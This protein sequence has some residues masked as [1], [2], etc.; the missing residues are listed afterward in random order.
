M[1]YGIFAQVYNELMDDSLFLKWKDYVTT[2]LKDTDTKILEL[3]SGNGH[4]ALL[5]KQEGYDIEGLDL[6]AEM[7]AVA[8]SKQEAESVEFP[9]YQADMRDLSNFDTYQAIVSFC[10]TLCYL[11]TIEDLERVFS[12]VYS[13][14]DKNGFFLFDVFTTEHIQSLDG[15][16]FHDE[17]PGTMFIWDSYLGEHEYSIE[18]DLLFFKEL[19]NGLYKRYEELHKERTYPLEVYI[20]KLEA[21]G[22]KNIEVI[23]D[24]D[25]EIT[26]NNER[27]FFKAEK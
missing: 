17:I 4:L 20:S 9:L 6:S 26:G 19:D 8:K 22:F 10:D 11:E 3:G 12:E 14:L 25:Q 5:L 24:F 27:W 18:H 1:T 16:T 15:Y 13:H 23:A 7:L 21:A 2:H